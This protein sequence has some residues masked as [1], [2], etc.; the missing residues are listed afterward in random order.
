MKARIVRWGWQELNPCRPS[1]ILTGPRFR[2][3][4][5]R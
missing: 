2:L 1:Q 3:N 4:Q 5:L